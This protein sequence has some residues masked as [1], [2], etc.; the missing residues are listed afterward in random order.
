WFESLR[1]ILISIRPQQHGGA[2]LLLPRRKATHDLNIRYPIA[3][4]RL[5][6]ALIKQSHYGARHLIAIKGIHKRI[7]EP[8]GMI[9]ADLYFDLGTN[10]MEYEDAGQELKGAIRLIAAMARV[11][12]LV[13]MDRRLN[14]L[15]FGVEIMRSGDFPPAYRAFD[16]LGRRR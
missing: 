8:N 4:T 13:L 7:L 10:E 2:V 14:V 16:D 11:D 6:E 12:G 9:P 3:Y 15:G 5:R 1:R